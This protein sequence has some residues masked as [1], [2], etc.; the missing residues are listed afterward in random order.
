LN[1]ESNEVL[2]IDDGDILADNLCSFQ[3]GGESSL[4]L[5]V[6]DGLAWAANSSSDWTETELLCLVL[7]QSVGVD[8][9]RGFEASNRIGRATSWAERKSEL[10]W[11]VDVRCALEIVQHDEDSNVEVL[12]VDI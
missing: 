5:H 12:V 6:E 4:G 7:V 8:E 1:L 9:L 10:D 3:A 11:L 2:S